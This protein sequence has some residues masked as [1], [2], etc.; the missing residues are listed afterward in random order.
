VF[1][2]LVKIIDETLWMVDPLGGRQDQM[3]STLIGRPLA[4]VQARLTLELN[5]PPTPC[6][7]WQ[8]MASGTPSGGLAQPPWSPAPITGEITNLKFPVRLG[9]L[10]LRNDGL[11]G[12]YLTSDYGTFHAVHSGAPDDTYVRAIGPGNY[13]PLA[14]DP[15]QSVRIA[16]IVDPRGA[17]H[18]TS[19]ILPTTLTALPAHAVERFLA[20]LQ[21]TFRTGPILSDAGALRMAEPAEDQ[22]SWAWVQRVGTGSGDDAWETAPIVDTTDAARLSDDVPQL[23]EGWLKLTSR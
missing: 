5:G 15:A 14:F 23:R 6:Q 3:F 4:V 17:V 19:G 16:M 12:Y 18:A 10:D 2:D 8:T 1:R 20:G 21:V 11:V 22:G 13:L 9:S 7:F